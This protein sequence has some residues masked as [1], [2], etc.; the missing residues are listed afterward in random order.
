MFLDSDRE[1]LWP[2]DSF[3]QIVNWPMNLLT[4]GWWERNKR[5]RW[6]QFLEAGDFTVWPFWSGA[7][8][9]SV[10]QKPRLLRSVAQQGN[11]PADA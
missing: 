1:Y 6:E 8:L 10:I 5:K 11:N 9:E 4:L 7:E 2:E 3:L